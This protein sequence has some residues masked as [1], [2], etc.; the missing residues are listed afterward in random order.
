MPTTPSP[1]PSLPGIGKLK[2]LTPLRRPPV[3][4]T[5]PRLLRLSS[6]PEERGGPGEP[7]IG[8]VTAHTSRDEW[9]VYWAFAKVTKDPANPRQAPYVGGATW[10][11]QKAVDGG[12]VVGGQVVD[13]VYMHPDDQT[14]GFRIQTEHWHIMTDSAKQMDD[15]FLKSSQTSIDQIIDLYSHMWVGDPSGKKV[16][17]I[18]ANGIKGIQSYSPNFAGTAQRIRPTQ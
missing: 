11:Y 17:A 1:I 13:F 8:F 9:Q 4:M 15:F 3:R 2:P 6:D 10:S 12:R 14:T 18:V 7:P 5:G 16:C